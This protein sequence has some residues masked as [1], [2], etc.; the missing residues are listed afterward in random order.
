ML[1]P[2]LTQDDLTLLYEECRYIKS[3]HPEFRIGQ[4][5]M[6]ALHKHYPATYNLV[7]GTDKDPF[8]DDEK[9]ESFLNF[10]FE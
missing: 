6:N 3:A 5:W 10:I 1:K 2:L 7:T 8:Y 9:I 4:S